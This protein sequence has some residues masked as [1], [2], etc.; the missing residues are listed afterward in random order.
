VPRE[1]EEE[2]SSAITKP[3]T[4]Q[5]IWPAVDA[6]SVGQGIQALLSDAAAHF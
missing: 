1:K 3:E 4:R 2:A 5:G 6:E